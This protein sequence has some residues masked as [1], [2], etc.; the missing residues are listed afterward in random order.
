MTRGSFS[1]FLFISGILTALVFLLLLWPHSRFSSSA[2]I[3]LIL[4]LI[5]TFPS[6]Y[7]QKRSKYAR[8]IH[9][10]AVL[11]TFVFFLVILPGQTHIARVFLVAV[12]ILWLSLH[13]YLLPRT[14]AGK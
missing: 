7:K 11:F 1:F 9:L 2:L 5:F 8:L 3:W 6:P 4:P 13:W 10:L 12:F 14:S